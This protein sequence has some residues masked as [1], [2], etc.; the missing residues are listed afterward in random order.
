MLQPKDIDWPNG[1]KNKTHI[2]AVHT[3]LICLPVPCQ[4]TSFNSTSIYDVLLSWCIVTDEMLRQRRERALL[5]SAWRAN[6]QQIVPHLREAG[7]TSIYFQDISKLQHI[8]FSYFAFIHYRKDQL[9]DW[10]NT[11]WEIFTG[12]AFV[13]ESWLLLQQHFTHNSSSVF[14]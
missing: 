6:N 7:F 10:G 5:S 3:N 2:N 12:M 11:S 9:L 4:I 13:F 1:Y 8:V 14:I